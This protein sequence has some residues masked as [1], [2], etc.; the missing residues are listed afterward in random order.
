M[1]TDYHPRR[2]G[3]ETVPTSHDVSRARGKLMP[4]TETD[5]GAG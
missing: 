2:A 3:G 1:P 5:G 4:C